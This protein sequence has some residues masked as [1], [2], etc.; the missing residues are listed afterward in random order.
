MSRRCERVCRWLF[1]F[2]VALSGCAAPGLGLD[3]SRPFAKG[4]QWEPEIDQADSS[5]WRSTP[6][7]LRSEKKKASRMDPVDELL[8][9]DEARDI[10]RNVGGL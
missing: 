5:D 8:W 6:A 7:S 1:L 2:G 3:K 10:G 4:E 9:S